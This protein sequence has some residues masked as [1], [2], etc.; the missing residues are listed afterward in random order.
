ML[1]SICGYEA[2]VFP[3]QTVSKGLAGFEQLEFPT[4]SLLKETL[5]KTPVRAGFC[6]SEG[7]LWLLLTPLQKA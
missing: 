1:E 2:T 5:R 4:P 3:N 6:R 7:S